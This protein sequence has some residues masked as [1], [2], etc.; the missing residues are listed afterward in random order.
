MFNG[1][2][3]ITINEHVVFLMGPDTF[4]PEYISFAAASDDENEEIFYNCDLEFVPDQ[5]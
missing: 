1:M 2:Y 5:S 3:R 4:C